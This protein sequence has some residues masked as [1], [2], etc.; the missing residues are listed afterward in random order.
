M[1]LEL[2]FLQGHG[3]VFYYLSQ[4]LSNHG[5]FMV[6]LH[7]MAKTDS[8]MCIYCMNELDNAEHTFFH[9]ERWQE[10]RQMV[11]HVLE[12]LTPETII[13]KML[14]SEEN[15]VTVPT[16]VRDVLMAKKADCQAIGL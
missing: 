3:E 12:G 10:E 16:F 1:Q 9:C 15:W 4:F 6:Y 14:V 8:S 7:R 13:H 11:E 2:W 5:L